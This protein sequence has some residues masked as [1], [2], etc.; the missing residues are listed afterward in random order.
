MGDHLKVLTK[1]TFKKGIEKGVVLVDFYA[2]WCGPCRMLTPVLEKVAKEVAGQAS[3]VKLDL[4][5]SQEIASFYQVT[6]VP[7]MILFR[8]GREVG[9][10]VGLR[11]ADSLKDFIASAATV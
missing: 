10:L 6:A 1:E 11:D 3:I 2:D 5:E 7:T 9:R 4:D 8:E